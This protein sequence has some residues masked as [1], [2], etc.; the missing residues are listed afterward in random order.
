MLDQAIVDRVTFGMRV[1]ARW[2]LDPL[3]DEDDESTGAASPLRDVEL[4]RIA[5]VAIE[6][7]ARFQREGIDIDPLAWMVTPRRMFAGR[8]PIEA[9]VTADACS[10]A[11][12]VHGLG[13]GLDPDP[14]AIDV[15]MTNDEPD[16]RVVPL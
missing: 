2:L 11:I 6:T 9:C 14:E 1:G 16:L 12:L 13:L 4:L 5:L 8:P 3:D 10:R 15:L 7:G